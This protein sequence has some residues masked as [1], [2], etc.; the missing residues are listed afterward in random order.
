MTGADNGEQQSD[1]SFRFLAEAKKIF[2]KSS[3]K[4]R[5][6]WLN[7]HQ[8]YENKTIALINK[9][10]T[11][12]IVSE[13]EFAGEL[14]AKIKMNAGI[15]YTFYAA[16]I[17]EYLKQRTRNQ[18]AVFLSLLRNFDKLKWKTVLNLRQ[19]L[20]EG[21]RVPFTPSLGAEGNLWK[22]VSARANVSRSFRVPTLNDIFWQP[23]GNPDLKPESGWNAETGLFL[24]QSDSAKVFTPSASVSVFSSWIDNWIVWQPTTFSYWQPLNLQKVWARGLEASSELKFRKNKTESR[25]Q[26]FYSYTLSTIEETSALL[27][28]SLGKQ[29]IYVPQHNLNGILAFRWKNISLT[30]MQIFT[31]KRYTTSD[32]NSSLPSFTIGNTVLNYDLRLNKITVSAG[33]RVNNIWNTNYQAIAYRPMP[34]RNFSFSIIIHYSQPNQQTNN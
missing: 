26:I 29:L 33:V 9:P 17:Q 23:G 3:L 31:G 7:E 28:A 13:A 22:I 34:G 16:N 32:N 21:Y 19:E 5:V 15:N 6:A 18:G 12:G 1:S 24:S 4:A 20:T 10:N 27:Q 8:R 25:I 2:P 11:Q 30:Y 14:F